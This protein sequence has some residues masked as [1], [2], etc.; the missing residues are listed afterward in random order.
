MIGRPSG[1]T[2]QTAPRP[3]A[4]WREA[5]GRGEVAAEELARV[6]DHTL[7][8]AQAT[9]ADIEALCDEAVRYGF[10][11]VCVNSVH[12]PM[13]AARLGRG[14]APPGDAGDTLPGDAGG[15][16]PGPLRASGPPAVRVC[17]VVG[18][19]L[20]AMATEAKAFEAG[21]AVERGADEIDMVV[22]V[23]YL[24]A[25]DGAFV[26]ADIRAVVIAA[27]RAGERRGM[28]HPP[29][30][31]V[32]VETCYLTDDE[33]VEACRRA[34]AAGADFVKTSTGF[35]PGGATPS[36]VA[37]L[38]R[39]VGEGLGVKASGGIRDLAAALAMIAAGADRLGLSAGVGVIE[40][41]R[42]RRDGPAVP[43]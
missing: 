13:A 19:P 24:K 29:L 38:R 2:W 35:G 37:L 41:A 9:P 33:K 20:G 6:M 43:G 12:V 28:T 15:A 22:P 18:F 30:V 40:A 26:E 31:K 4:A 36:D 16:P 1:E 27:R 14:A 39:T 3:T 11:A 8:K 7:L 17:A 32:I 5:A 42:A 34:A 10:G 21:W 25:G 23:G